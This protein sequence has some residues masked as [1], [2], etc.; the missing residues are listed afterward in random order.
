MI[1]EQ[2]RVMRAM[3]V[4]NPGQYRPV[5]PCERLVEPTDES[6]AF[7][8]AFGNEWTVDDILRREG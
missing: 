8:D 6:V 4:E 1:D 3:G 2:Q 7:E 5:A